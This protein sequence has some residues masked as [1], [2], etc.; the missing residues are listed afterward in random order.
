MDVFLQHIINGVAVGTIYSLIALGYTM[1]YGILSLVNFAH[2]D[3]FMI[4]AFSGYYVARW[5]GIGVGGADHPFG[6]LTLVMMTAMMVCAALAL[7][8]ER[9]AYR[10]LRNA[11]R[12][13]VLITA[14]GVSLFLEYA[15]QV[16]FGADPKFF[17]Q[18][19]E[20]K[21]LIASGALH[22]TNVQCLTLA[23]SLSLMAA[24][25]L[26]I[27]KT[28]TGTAMRAVS[29]SYTVS[30]LMGISVNKIIVV[31]FLIGSALAGA[32]GVL[33]SCAYPKIEPLMG[34]LPG[35]KAFVAAVL[36]GIGHI[37]GA[38]FGGIIIGLLE[39]MIV[40]Y[41]YSSYRD[42]L[43]F[44]ILILILLYRPAGLFGNH[45]PEKV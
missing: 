5:L 40:G 19:F 9:F 37:P 42:G 38:M 13:N 2:S 24:L 6:H 43:A 20:T 25:H 17:P 29:H 10:P 26:F 28:R 39:E 8:I 27:H 16:L 34:V 12:L 31:T 35:L 18:F 4:G 7:I 23:I 14:I 41:G 36:G 45:I 15:G 3:V 22:I 44:A 33:V 30:S 11:P 21:P 1:V 32:A